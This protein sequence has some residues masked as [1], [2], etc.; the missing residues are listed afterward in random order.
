M[1]NNKISIAMAAY[2]G[3]KYIRQQIESMC[4]QTIKPDEIIISDDGS[5]DSTVSIIKELI[6]KYSSKGI[7]I[8]L[9]QDNPRHGY[10]GNFEWAISHTSG[11]FIFVSDQDDIWYFNKI[12]SILQFFYVILTLSVLFMRLI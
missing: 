12:E 8:K 3:E 1:L 6:H 2:N 10:C 9:L 11:D 5:S 4:E 7:V